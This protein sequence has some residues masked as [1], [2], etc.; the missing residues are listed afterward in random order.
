ME[1]FAWKSVSTGAGCFYFFG[2]ML[3]G[4]F[5]KRSPTEAALF[6]LRFACLG[7]Q[8]GLLLLK[9]LDSRLHPL[10]CQSVSDCSRYPLV[11][12]DSLV[13]LRAL[14]AHGKVPHSREWQRC[15]AHSHMTIEPLNCSGSKLGHF[16]IQLRTGRRQ[17]NC[18]AFRMLSP[19]GPK[20]HST[21][22]VTRSG[23]DGSSRMAR[24]MN[25]IIYTAR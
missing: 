2:P 1:R 3:C 14:V 18:P 20:P 21:E 7:V 25:G 8:S 12:L 11:L 24:F 19:L 16:K 5:G 10:D 23:S 4:L 13:E 9:V 17:R 6:F 22:L 15:H